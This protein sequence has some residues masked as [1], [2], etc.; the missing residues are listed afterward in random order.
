MR[1]YKT[2]EYEVDLPAAQL[3]AAA[4]GRRVEAASVQ[5]ELHVR[6]PETGEL[7]AV[8]AAAALADYGLRGLDGRGFHSSTSQLNLKPFLSL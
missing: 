2:G 7:E 1:R 3:R 4:D 8:S 6:N 5:G